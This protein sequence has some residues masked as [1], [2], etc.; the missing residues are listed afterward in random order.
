ME[1]KMTIDE[2]INF[3]RSKCIIINATGIDSEIIDG[4]TK[5]SM[6]YNLEFNENQIKSMLLMFM[7]MQEEL[8]TCNKALRLAC[9]SL[10]REMKYDDRL[11]TSVDEIMDY[12]LKEAEKN[13]ESL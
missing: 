6:K 13:H 4:I 8:K 3:D 1:N 10:Y 9:E 2:I 7:P 12:C 11:M 5:V